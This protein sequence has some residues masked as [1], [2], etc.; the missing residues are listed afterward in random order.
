ML[1][2]NP[3]LFVVFL[4]RTVGAYTYVNKQMYNVQHCWFK[5][6]CIPVYQTNSS[7]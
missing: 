6:L 3:Q 7:A 5:S 4:K 1:K 2:W